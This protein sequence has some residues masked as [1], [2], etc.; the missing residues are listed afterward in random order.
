MHP[1]NLQK[2]SKFIRFASHVLFH[3]RHYI[4]YTL[5]ILIWEMLT[6][7]CPWDHG[8]GAIKACARNTPIQ[9]RA[10]CRVVYSLQTS[11]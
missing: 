2:Q 5:P 9:A 8:C 1:I 3:I 11:W 4:P 7:K 6:C 10:P